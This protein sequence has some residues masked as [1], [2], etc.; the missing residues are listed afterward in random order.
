M[1]W[2]LDLRGPGLGL[3]VAPAE[4]ASLLGPT[5]KQ[6]REQFVTLSSCFPQYRCNSF[7]FRTPVLLHLLLDLDTYG[8][9]DP[10][11]ISSI[12]KMVADIIAPKPHKVFPGLFSMGS[13][14]EC[15]RSS[16]ATAIPKCAPTP[17]RENYH[18][19][20]ITPILSKVPEKLVSHKLYSFCEVYGFLPAVL[21]AY[22]KGLGCT[23]ALLTISAG[24]S[25]Q[26]THCS[27]PVS[28]I[29]S[30]WNCAA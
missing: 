7:P 4:K 18:S 23:D 27:S 10:L 1:G 14:P 29:N 12:S 5:S 13:F 22:K 20:S 26:V 6:C 24:N 25:L 15:W 3:V 11:G 28:P 19:I 9:V 8:G 2:K 30:Q 21:F 17:D 16:N